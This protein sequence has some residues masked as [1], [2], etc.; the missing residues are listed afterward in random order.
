MNAKKLR[1]ILQNYYAV[2]SEMP[3]LVVNGKRRP[4]YEIMLELQEK[5]NIPFEA[6]LDIPKFLTSLKEEKTNKES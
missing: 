2:K 6:W 3:S 1:Q 5:E 4:R